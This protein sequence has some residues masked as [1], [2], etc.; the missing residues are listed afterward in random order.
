VGQKYQ[1]GQETIRQ[2]H[3]VRQLPSVFDKRKQFHDWWPKEKA[4]LPFSYIQGKDASASC[5][6]DLTF[7]IYNMDPEFDRMMAGAQGRA[8]GPQTRGDSG[9]P[10]K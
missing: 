1:R 4:G 9:V 7:N 5:S 3:F 6:T 2:R 8:G 10:D